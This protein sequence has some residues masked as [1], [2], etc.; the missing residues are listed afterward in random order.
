MTKSWLGGG[1]SRGHRAQN[2]LDLPPGGGRAGRRAGLCQRL[3]HLMR[4]MPR[5]GGARGDGE[6][7]TSGV[8]LPRSPCPSCEEPPISLG[9]PP[10]LP[11][12]ASPP[13]SKVLI[14]ALS[15]VADDQKIREGPGPSS[16]FVVWR[17]V[18]TEGFEV[19]SG[20]V[21]VQQL[22]G[23]RALWWD[24]GAAWASL[25]PFSCKSHLH[26]AFEDPRDVLPRPLPP[27]KW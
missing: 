20:R 14:G 8:L 3:P 10:F 18:I 12:L 23:G 2:L 24:G 1:S 5:A 21:Q 17:G 6:D 15:S 11:S 25:G 7:L 27:P 16:R 19:G 22:P 4:V 9:H 26:S 13:A